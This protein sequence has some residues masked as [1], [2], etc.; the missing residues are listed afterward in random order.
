M[1]YGVRPS[2]RLRGAST[3]IE[4][5]Q[6]IAAIR[7]V[8]RD[9]EIAMRPIVGQASKDQMRTGH[10]GARGRHSRRDGGETMKHS[11]AN[12]CDCRRCCNERHRR[13]RQA[14]ANRP[15]ASVMLEWSHSRNRQRARVSREYWDAY[16]SGRPMS[17][18]DR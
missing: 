15:L 10:V 12:T 7:G 18:D 2:D 6:R 11:Y 3:P 13:E 1:I 4:R 8:I 5:Y 14:D 16:E 17:D 9:M